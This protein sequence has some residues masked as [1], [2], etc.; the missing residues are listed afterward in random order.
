[1]TVGRRV[2]WRGE[3]V[4]DATLARAFH[5]DESSR[6]GKIDPEPERPEGLHPAGDLGYA[7]SQGGRRDRGSR[8]ILCVGF[9][10]QRYGGAARRRSLA[11]VSTHGGG[12]R[13]SLCRC[14]SAQRRAGLCRDRRPCGRAAGYLAGRDQ[15]RKNAERHKCLRRGRPQTVIVSRV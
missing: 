8:D 11:Q 14:R 12:R 9:R 5:L 10:L 1:V 2:R 4:S 15:Q 7:S 13:A 6:N 3:L